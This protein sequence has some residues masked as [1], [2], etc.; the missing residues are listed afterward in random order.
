MADELNTEN[1][2]A[3]GVSGA[4]IVIL[5]PPR[6]SMSKSDALNLA[7]WIVALADN[8]GLFSATLDNVRST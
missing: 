2:Y 4:N 3:V 8:D 6:G 7:A 5:R 1:R